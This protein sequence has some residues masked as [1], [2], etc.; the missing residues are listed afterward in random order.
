MKILTVLGL[1]IISLMLGYFQYKPHSETHVVKDSK[2]ESKE[3][4]E[5]RDL[6]YIL[7]VNECLFDINQCNHIERTYEPLKASL[8]VLLNNYHE[9]KDSISYYATFSF[10]LYTLI[11]LGSV[12][13]YPQMIAMFSRDDFLEVMKMRHQLFLSDLVLKDVH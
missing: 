1:L 12:T 11:A 5:A 7:Q 6:A 10:D 8:S 13:D 9:K 4:F 3:I 2:S